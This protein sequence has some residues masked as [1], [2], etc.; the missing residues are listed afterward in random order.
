MINAENDN[1]GMLPKDLT[2]EDWANLYYQLWLCSRQ[3]AK[4]EWPE[5]LF[6][7]YDDLAEE[8]FRLYQGDIQP[9]VQYL[10]NPRYNMR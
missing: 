1:F 4:E 2:S 5:G 7:L 3:Q 9:L 8:S 6:N 10:K